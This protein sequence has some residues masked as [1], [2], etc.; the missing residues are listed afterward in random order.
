MSTQHFPHTGIWH[1]VSG[2]GHR[3]SHFGM[4]AHVSLLLQAGCAL[5][6]GMRYV[7][8]DDNWMSPMYGQD[9]AVVSTLVL[10]TANRTGPPETF[11]TYVGDSR[12]GFLLSLSLSSCSYVGRPSLCYRST[13]NDRV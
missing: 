6:T 8:K 2:I 5:F 9:I 7:A 1:L 3:P 12:V 10:G 11:D 4:F 13:V